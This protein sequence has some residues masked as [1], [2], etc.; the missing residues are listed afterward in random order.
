MTTASGD[1]TDLNLHSVEEARAAA[2]QRSAREGELGDG[3][4]APLVEAARPVGDAAAALQVLRHAGVVLPLLCARQ[5]E[6]RANS[7][8][9]DD[10]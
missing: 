6:A 5:T 2:D 9:A 10:Y 4:V 1:K 3:M 7:Q 8:H